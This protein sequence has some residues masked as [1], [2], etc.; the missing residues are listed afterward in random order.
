MHFGLNP[1]TWHDT[2]NRKESNQYYISYYW[3]S[4]N[5]D[6]K[7]H[8]SDI[9]HSLKTENTFKVDLL[10]FICCQNEWICHDQPNDAF[11]TCLTY[12]DWCLTF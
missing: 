7:G 6:A 2:G 5:I 11:D 3:Y 9:C 12:G 10:V 8:I 1:E 4:T